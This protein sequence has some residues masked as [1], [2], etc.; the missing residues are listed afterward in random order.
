MRGDRQ[1]NWCKTRFWMLWVGKTVMMNTRW[2]YCI[3]KSIQNEWL[4]TILYSRFVILLLND[5]CDGL[6]QCDHSNQETISIP[7]LFWTILIWWIDQKLWWIQGEYTT[8]SNLSKMN[9]LW[10]HCTH[11]LSYCYWTMNAMDYIVAHNQ[12]RRQFP[13]QACFEPFWFDG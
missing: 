3:I 12:I 11:V 6:Y 13:F 1:G 9:S 4:V 5:E 2:V 8:S 7:S 10:Q